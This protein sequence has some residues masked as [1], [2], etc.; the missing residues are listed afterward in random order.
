MLCYA[1]IYT[2]LYFQ[3]FHSLCYIVMYKKIPT[4]RS[5]KTQ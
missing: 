4:I 5:Q 2:I 3:C 1:V